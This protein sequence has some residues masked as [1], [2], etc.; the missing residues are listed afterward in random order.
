MAAVSRLL[1]TDLLGKRRSALHE[2]RMASLAELEHIDPGLVA[3]ANS[4]MLKGGYMTLLR[5]RAIH[6]RSIE[7]RE[8]IARFDEDMTE[9]GNWTGPEVERLTFFTKSPHG[10][11]P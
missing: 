10:D 11:S 9:I 1:V 7:R 4:L 8:C 5:G 3:D 6:A 2:K